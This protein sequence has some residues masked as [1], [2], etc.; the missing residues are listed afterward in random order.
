MRLC[1]NKGKRNAERDE[2][3]LC[4]MLIHRPKA[5]S[6]ARCKTDIVIWQECPAIKGLETCRMWVFKEGRRVYSCKCLVFSP[7]CLVI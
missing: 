5:V 2:R 4:K 6:L 3:E 1:V 7:V